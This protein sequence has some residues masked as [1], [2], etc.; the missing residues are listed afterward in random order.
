MIA[1]DLQ[2]PKNEYAPLFQAIQGTGTK[3]W[4]YLDS[5]WLVY[6]E[7]SV[8]AVGLKLGDLIQKKDGSVLVMEVTGEAQGIL[9]KESWKW[10]NETAAE[11]DKAPIL[12]TSVKRKEVPH[13][14]V[15][16][17]WG[18]GRLARQW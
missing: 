11:A 13:T 1:Y 18:S 6:T 4:H 15:C 7:E 8:E 5:F 2:G 10:I 14:N 16:T 3:W 17:V 12:Q 9:P